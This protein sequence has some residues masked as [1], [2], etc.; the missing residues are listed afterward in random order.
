MALNCID[1]K[2]DSTN[3]TKPSM[4]FNLSH[5]FAVLTGLLG[6]TA[7]PCALCYSPGSNGI[8]DRCRQRYFQDQSP[9]CHCCGNSLPHSAPDANFLLCGECL[10][11]TPSFDET[12]VAV[13]YEPPLDQLVHL[14][15][16][17]YRLALAPLMGKLIY[18]ATVKPGR[19]SGLRPDFIIAVP[20]GKT[21]LIERGFN[22]SHEIAKKLAKLMKIPLLSDLVYRNRETEKQST[23]SFHERK[24]NVHNAF[25]L[26]ETGRFSIKEKHIGIVDDVMTTGHTLE[27]IARLLKKSGAKRV[28]NFVFARTL[29]KTFQE[30]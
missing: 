25:D 21:R 14:L 19:P 6:K 26:A 15:K 12:I 23:V 4:S 29:P 17:Q 16:F 13:N 22:Q 10:E 30:N 24:K 11:N 3:R 1:V 28:T 5:C 27:E 2:T 7:H 9:R 20:L 18:Q 8:C